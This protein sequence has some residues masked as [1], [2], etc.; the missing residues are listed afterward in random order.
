MSDNFKE[1]IDAYIKLYEIQVS[2]FHKRVDVE[3]KIFI[4]SLTAL[5][6]ATGY[7]APKID[8][9]ILIIII[10]ITILI[11][12]IVAWLIGIWRA[13][14]I[15]KRWAS[16]YRSHVEKELA[17]V[18]KPLEFKSPTIREFFKDW[19]MICQMFLMIASILL[20]LLIIH[21]V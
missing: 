14:E 20:S 10:F 15:D 13:N 17:I 12:Y 7:L 21:I 3:W 11:I 1:K 2:L 5:F 19:S 6:V 18:D 9:N 16:V 4:S 8:L